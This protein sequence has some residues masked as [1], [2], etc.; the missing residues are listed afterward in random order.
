MLEVCSMFVVSHTL[1]QR[2]GGVTS[3]FA[4]PFCF[5]S[6]T[7]IYLATICSRTSHPRIVASVRLIELVCRCDLLSFAQ[8]P[9]LLPRSFVACLSVE[10]SEYSYCVVRNSSRVLQIASECVSRSWLCEG[11]ALCGSFSRFAEIS[12]SNSNCFVRVEPVETCFVCLRR[13]HCRAM[14]L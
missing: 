9:A 8:C 5:A 12:G 11:V 13:N 10:F 7:A 14:S 6:S 2:G 3:H 4:R 1:L